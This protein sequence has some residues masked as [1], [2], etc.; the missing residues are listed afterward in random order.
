MNWEAP[1]VFRRG[2]SLCISTVIFTDLR[3]NPRDFIKILKHR[4]LIF[5]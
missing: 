4:R 1:S 2:S 5:D 3:Q